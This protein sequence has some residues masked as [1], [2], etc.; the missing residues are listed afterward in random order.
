MAVINKE[1]M[2]KMGCGSPGCD[3]DHSILFLV[4][5]CHPSQGLEVKFVKEKD[6]LVVSC[7]VCEAEVTT[8]QL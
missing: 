4:Q 7:F 6:Q 1:E 2:K 3:H 8:V 5:G